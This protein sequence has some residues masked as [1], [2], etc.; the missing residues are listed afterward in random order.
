[1]AEEKE[2]LRKTAPAIEVKGASQTSNIDQL[3]AENPGVQFMN[4]SAGASKEALEVA[5]LTPVVDSA[6]KPIVK[7]GQMVCRCTNDT[8]KKLIREGFKES[9]A[10]IRAVRPK[11][12]SDAVSFKKNPAGFKAPPVDAEVR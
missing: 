1:M 2:I 8:Q 12:D 11:E 7:K 6:G 5:G 4:C 9:T 3:I 10:Q